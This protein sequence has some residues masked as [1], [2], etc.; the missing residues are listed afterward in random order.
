MTTKKKTV[1]NNVTLDKKKDALEST[2]FFDTLQVSSINLSTLEG[3]TKSTYAR[4]EQYNIIDIMSQD[5]RNRA[6]LDTYTQYMTQPNEFG[7]IVWAD[8]EDEHIKYYI[9]HLID[10]LEINKNIY[11][12]VYRLLKYG[13]LYL[14]LYKQSE[15]DKFIQP[16]KKS[17]LL[18]EG[19]VVK[20]EDN[21]PYSHY[22]SV[23]SDPGEFVELTQFGKTVGFVKVPASSFSNYS[24]SSFM[25]NYINYNIQNKD[26]ELYGP[27]SY[28]HICLSN[29]TDRVEETLFLYANDKDLENG[30]PSA[31]YTIKSGE[32][33]LLPGYKVWR[34][35][36]LLENSILLDRVSRSSV[37]RFIEIDSGN[38]DDDAAY[39]KMMDL[40]NTIEQKVAINTGANYSNYVEPS[41]IQNIV[42]SVKHGNDGAISMQTMGGDTETKSL[43][44][45]D[46][47]LNR[48]YG[49]FG[50]PKQ[51]LGYTDDN[52]G[53]NGGTSLTLISSSFSKK[54][55]TKKIPVI[56][57]IT[58][59]IKII[60]LSE[61][62]Y[63]YLN[64]FT[65][66]MQS[67]S[68]QEDVDR[69][70]ALKAKLEITDSILQNID[71]R[72]NDDLTKL[73][74]FKAMLPDEVI[75]A[76]V[77]SL[78]Q[79][80]IDKIESQ[81]NEGEN[82]ENNE[83]IDQDYDSSS[84]PNDYDAY[85]NNQQNPEGQFNSPV[86]PM[87]IPQEG[88]QPI[89]Q[90]ANESL[91]EET[92]TRILTEDEEGEDKLRFKSANELGIN[93]LDKKSIKGEK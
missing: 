85:L 28:V 46:Q 66:K 20:Q 84:Y 89:E 48:Y 26:T 80:Y 11:N 39:G 36:Q 70:N 81:S 56:E 12:W 50:I 92:E 93:L 67:S 47:W 1:I 35:L 16:K 2:S 53:F 10:D 30:T 64:K 75:D 54:V 76:N 72:V 86:S 17:T 37:V 55:E 49:F 58:T 52:T 32:S 61:G 88:P 18:N 74:I 15:I 4:D 19:V 27:T 41:P 33:L 62:K 77:S 87:E 43:V 57:G 60:L 23:V 91:E 22:I 69:R 51:F 79:D 14:K 8:S 13:D 65:I 3:I 7:K 63:D 71:V 24:K 6:V 5:D 29:D 45:L 25:G 59:L 9:N 68:T 83:M 31:Q 38:A 44:D 78:L 40:K 90:G 42:Y 73:K 82:M 21:T 34:Q